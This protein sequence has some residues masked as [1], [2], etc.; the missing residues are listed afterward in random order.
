MDNK[1]Q[2]KT[3]LTQVHLE[4]PNKMVHLWVTI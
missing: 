2:T 1:N 3:Q 4:M